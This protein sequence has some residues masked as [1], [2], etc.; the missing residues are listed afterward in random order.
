MQQ[1]LR[2]S[3]LLLGGVFGPLLFVVVFLIEG[4]TRPNY[5][6][7]RHS[8]SQLSLGEQGWINSLSIFICGL[9]LLGFALGIKRVLPS[10]G[11][12]LWGGR[13]A[14]FGSVCF[15]LLAFF[16]TNPSLGYPPQVVPTYTVPG[17]IHAIAATIFFGCLS[18]LCFVLGQRS[19]G[20]KGWGLFSRIIGS[21]VAITYVATVV[22]T[23]LDM[24][25]KWVEAPG[26]FLERLTL[27][28]GLGWVMILAFHLLQMNPPAQTA[29]IRTDEQLLK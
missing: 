18:A 9:C 14:E 10:G 28:S 5:N 20:G 23:S 8:V 26:G 6:P 2:T 29:P 21:M 13:L 25:G 16:A 1:R 15:L 19:I 4:A 3:A 27:I 11:R 7:W 17:L 12:M 24:S 22:V